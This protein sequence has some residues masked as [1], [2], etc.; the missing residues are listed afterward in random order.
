MTVLSQSRQSKEDHHL[1]DLVTSIGQCKQTKQKYS[2]R[3]LKQLQASPLHWCGG[4]RC[5]RSVVSTC[6]VHF[7]IYEHFSQID[8]SFSE[9]WFVGVVA[10][11][12]AV[13]VVLFVGVFSAT[14]TRGALA[15]S[16]VSISILL[17]SNGSNRIPVV[18]VVDPQPHPEKSI[19]KDDSF[20]H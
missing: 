14:V 19:D 5:H 2:H 17:F 4:C 7:S 6:S 18:W 15:T 20:L 16:G 11:A 8:S 3:K 1:T 9:S 10:T 13:V 12:A